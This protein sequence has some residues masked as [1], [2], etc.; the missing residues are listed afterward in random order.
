MIIEFL[1]SVFFKKDMINN[2]NTPILRNIMCPIFDRTIHIRKYFRY[3]Y[4]YLHNA[5]LEMLKINENSKNLMPSSIML[6]TIK[7]KL[8]WKAKYQSQR[9]C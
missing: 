9:K 7:K 4:R 8:L 3:V 6:N 5:C 1:L 2:K